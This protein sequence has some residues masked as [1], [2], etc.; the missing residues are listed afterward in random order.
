M[1]YFYVC[2]PSLHK[3]KTSNLARKSFAAL[4]QHQARSKLAKMMWFCFFFVV[5]L[6]YIKQASRIEFINLSWFKVNED[7]TSD[8]RAKQV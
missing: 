5:I 7:V 6:I 4:L 8:Y 1:I 2:K 3:T